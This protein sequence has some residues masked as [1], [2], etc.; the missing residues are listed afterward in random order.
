MLGHD[1]EPFF[2]R[3]VRLEI[4]EHNGREPKEAVAGF[5][6]KTLFSCRRPRHGWTSSTTLKLNPENANGSKR[7]RRSEMRGDTPHPPL[8]GTYLHPYRKTTGR[9]DIQCD[10]LTR[11]CLPPTLPR[12]CESEVDTNNDDQKKTR[13]KGNV[14]SYFVDKVGAR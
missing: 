9:L 1:L 8:V 12:T 3:D 6:Q 14:K 2:C 5:G 13:G 11:T 10:V 4:Q 7:R